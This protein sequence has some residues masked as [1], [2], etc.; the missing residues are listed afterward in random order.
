MKAWVAKSWTLIAVTASFFVS[1]CIDQSITVEVNKNGTAIMTETTFMSSKSLNMMESMAQSLGGKSNAVTANPLLEKAQY[2]TKAKQMGEGVTL[3]SVKELKEV[4][5]GPGVEV[6]YNIADISNL[7]IVLDSSPSGGMGST[8]TDLSKFIT[9]DLVKGNI[10]KLTIHL[11]IKTT[12]TTAIAKTKQPTAPE[13]PLIKQIETT[14]TTG[15]TQAEEPIPPDFS[16]LKQILQDMRL[17][18]KVK[19]NGEIVKSNASNI[20]TDPVTKKRQMVVLYALDFSQMLDDKALTTLMSLQNQP[21]SVIFH[22]LAKIE[23]M[24]VEPANKVE[25]EFK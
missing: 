6:K 10:S 18:L 22:E 13:P 11:P 20:E 17:S 19:V 3:T 5:K 4:D 24:K 23:G 14:E 9:L 25:V 21:E 8:K 1:G 16:L 7:K 2:E 15:G 12:A